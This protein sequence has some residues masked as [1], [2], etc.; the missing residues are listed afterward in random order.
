[1]KEHEKNKI[2]SRYSKRLKEFGATAKTLGWDKER[3]FLRYH[4]LLSQWDYQ[5]DSVLDFGCGFGDMY[6]Y[7]QRNNLDIKYFGADINPALLNQG[8]Q[9]YP[10]VELREVDFLR[11]ENSRNYDYIMSSGVHNFKL[12][13]N[14]AFIE[15]TMSKFNQCASKGFALNFI[16]NKVDES[17][18]QDHLYYTDPVAVIEL[19]YS[20]S[21]RVTLRNDYMPFEFTIFVDKR[22]N[23]DSK[24]VIYNKYLKYC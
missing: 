4:I 19:A 11:E 21:R 18:K 2:I 5:G 1:M 6:Y 3:H 20:F 24:K 22:D 10:N 16:S 14:W 13:D 7:I 23:F 9:K 17:H 8:K 15:N 12:E